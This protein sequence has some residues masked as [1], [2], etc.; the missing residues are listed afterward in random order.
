MTSTKSQKIRL[1]IFAV[2]AAAAA[3]LILIVF[4]GL[5]F[6][7]KHDHYVVYFEDSVNGLEN[8]AVVTFAGIKAGK[9]AD[10]SIAP[11]DLRKVKVTIE[12][13]R[14]LPIRTDTT[15]T[16]TMAGITGL[17]SID[18]HGGDIRSPKLAP[19]DTIAAGLTTLDRFERQAK[20]I[21][22]QSRSIMGHADTVMTNLA[23]LTDPSHFSSLGEVLA[24]ARATTANLAAAS[25]QLNGLIAD[26]RVTIKRTVASIGHTMTS[27]DH[28]ADR[29]TVV[30]D[31]DLPR[32]TNG[33]SALVDELRGVV[34]DNGSYLRSSMFDLRQASRSFKELARDLRQKPSRLLFAGASRERKLP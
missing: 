10:I 13:K 22:D 17:K 30:L 7:E 25:A 1:G 20:E 4:A 34:R 28:L 2:A 24:S 16:L 12:V 5:R 31:E 19:G 21:L 9:V 8:G 6:W 18:L 3:A 11:D 15:A 33:A 27:I 32:V 14:G 23:S 29:A 26:N